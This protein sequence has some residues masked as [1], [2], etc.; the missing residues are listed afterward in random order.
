MDVSSQLL[1]L[2][3]LSLGKESLLLTEY[4]TG[5]VHSHSGHGG[6][7]NNSCLSSVAQSV[8]SC[9]TDSTILCLKQVREHFMFYTLF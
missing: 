5:L 9:F 1:A 6:R 8:A 3:A 2:P 4:E 7:E